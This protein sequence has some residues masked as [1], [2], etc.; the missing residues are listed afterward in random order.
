MSSVYQ[1]PSFKSTGSGN[2]L[3]GRVSRLSAE[4]KRAGPMT[5]IFLPFNSEKD[6]RTDRNA[7]VSSVSLL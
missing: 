3:A 6:A 1:P 5:K 4:T 7:F 2:T